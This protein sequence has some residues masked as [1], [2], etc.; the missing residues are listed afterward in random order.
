M[1]SS[2]PL[3]GREAAMC[4]GVQPE[5]SGMSGSK[6]REEERLLMMGR[7]EYAVAQWRGRRSSASRR[8]ESLGFVERKD[9]TA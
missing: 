7:W 2:P 9:S 8:E 5:A 6:E 3:D 4:R 1:M